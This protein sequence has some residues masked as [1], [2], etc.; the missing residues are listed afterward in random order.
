MDT[1]LLLTTG[2]R[3]YVYEGVSNLYHLVGIVLASLQPTLLPLLSGSHMSVLSMRRTDS[4]N[5]WKNHT[6]HYYGCH[7]ADVQLRRSPRSVRCAVR[8][9][10]HRGPGHHH[11][12]H[13]AA[14]SHRAPSVSRRSV[15]VL[16]DHG[17]GQC[18]L[19]RD[20]D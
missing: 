9:H 13:S 1:C 12:E 2:S 18:H 3:V 11:L 10:R 20:E 15:F 6:R 8:L 14:I 7:S 19:R 16:S 17:L 5:G 4:E